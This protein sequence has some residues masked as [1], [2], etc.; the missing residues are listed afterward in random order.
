VLAN[1]ISLPLQ[2]LQSTINSGCVVRPTW[3]Y[4]SWV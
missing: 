4:S 3:R 1:I 2:P